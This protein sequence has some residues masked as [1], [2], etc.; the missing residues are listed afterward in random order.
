MV[1]GGSRS[2]EVSLQRALGGEEPSGGGVKGWQVMMGRDGMMG[3]RQREA[4]S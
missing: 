3:H 2:G 4:W 1:E